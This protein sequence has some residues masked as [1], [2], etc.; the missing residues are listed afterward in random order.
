MQAAPEKPYWTR[1]PAWIFIGTALVLLPIFT[2]VTVRDINRQ[3]KFM[4]R[5]LVE[6]GAALIRSF[7]AATRTG[8]RGRMHTGFKLEHLLMETARQS[9]IVYLLLTDAQGQILFHSDPDHTGH[10][11]GSRIDLDGLSDERSVK[12]RWTGHKE[13][14]T[15]FE[16]YRQFLPRGP[17]RRR[18]P[19]HVMR[20]RSRQMMDRRKP[21]PELPRFIFVGLDAGS[22]AAAR[23]A[24]IRHTVVMGAVLL[25]IGAAGIFL[26]F[27][28]Q[29]YRTARVSLAR[30]KAFSD[31]LVDKMPIGL[32]AIDD[33]H[34]IASFNDTA[35]SILG[36]APDKAFGRQARQVLP[37][38]LQQVVERLDRDQEGI[39]EE[40]EC[41]LSDGSRIPVAVSASILS[42]ESGAPLGAVL[43]L[44]D[45]REL[46]ALRKQ[47][48]RNQRLV[49]VGRLAAGVAHEVRNPLSSIKGFATY[50]KERHRDKPEDQ[51]IA[52]IMIQEVERLNRVI[53][54][55]LDFA[56]PVK[57]NKKSVAVKKL[58]DRSIQMIEQQA[59]EK[60]ITVQLQVNPAVETISADADRLG[61]VL[62]NL[63]LNALEAMEQGGH[64]SIEVT[65]L[66]KS[67]E[68]AIKV[69]DT[70]C[71]IQPDEQG[72]IFD[73]Y[74]TTKPT[75]TGLGLAI[76]H[77]IIEAHGGRITVDSRLEQGTVCTIVLPN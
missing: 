51:Q 23:Q 59:K 15:I 37:A 53:S 12:W 36:F 17:P 22:I 3:K 61:Q 1:V 27:F 20:Q 58:I 26:L 50:F 76:A 28:A 63:Y 70:G 75:G 77:N 73:P 44:K 10:I 71:G 38:E 34:R 65:E 35:Q 4:T 39:E 49:S 24:D 30:I 40:L 5:L 13:D 72:Q 43:L 11:H 7:E 52:A 29:S 14:K 47:I 66:E 64:L 32:V 33:G 57:I 31:N 41:S 55:L 69:S 67:E 19:E 62:L 46:T 60:G 2:L 21:P 68:I 56:R 9:D 6:K 25:L 42:D 16:I 45:L 54:Q 74:Y 18:P 8:M 48:Q